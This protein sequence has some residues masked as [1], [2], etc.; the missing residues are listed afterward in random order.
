MAPLSELCVRGC[1]ISLVQDMHRCRV[2]YQV[3][4]CDRVCNMNYILYSKGIIFYRAYK[5]WMAN[6]QKELTRAQCIHIFVI[7]T[8]SV[9]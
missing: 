1:H 8:V 3:I 7:S 6:L 9:F 5:C 4:A 2:W